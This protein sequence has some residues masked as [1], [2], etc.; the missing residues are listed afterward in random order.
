MQPQ[1]IH[2]LLKHEIDT[3]PD[4]L[5]ESVFDFVLFLKERHSEELFLWQ[6]VEETNAYRQQHPEDVQTVIGEEWEQAA[7]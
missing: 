4:P 3:L 1:S 5:A 7:T 2:Q 6:Q